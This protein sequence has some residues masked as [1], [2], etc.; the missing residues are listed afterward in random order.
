MDLDGTRFLEGSGLWPAAPRLISTEPEFSGVSANLVQALSPPPDTWAWT[1]SE[2]RS[3][4]ARSHGWWPKGCVPLEAAA[5]PYP[6]EAGGSGAAELLRS[7]LP[8]SKALTTLGQP[9]WQTGLFG[10]LGSQGMGPP[11][12]WVCLRWGLPGKVTQG[13]Q[14]SRQA[15]EI[16]VGSDP[17]SAAT[18]PTNGATP[19]QAQQLCSP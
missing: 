14:E 13:L 16:L 3:P 15:A 8:S 9:E 6:E 12:A 17:A 19:P 1:R 4:W 18:L 2:P 11:S 7:S 5:V 10:I